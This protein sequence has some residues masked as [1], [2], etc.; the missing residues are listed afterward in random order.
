MTAFLVAR[1]AAVERGLPCRTLINGPRPVLGTAVP[2][3]G[4]SSISAMAPH[5]P[6][7]SPQ[8]SS[9]DPEFTYV[10]PRRTSCHCT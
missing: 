7:E 9:E 3:A 8:S 10:L 4:R 2:H 1:S 5:S 6:P